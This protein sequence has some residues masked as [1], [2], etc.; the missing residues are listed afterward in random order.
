VI[1]YLQALILG[2]LQG[3]TELFPVSS[4]GHSVILPR[5]F[6][7]NI[8]Q[9]DDAFVTFL[10]ATHFATA[11]TLFLYF[12]DDWRQIISGLLRTRN[13]QIAQDDHYAKLGW[14]LVV[15]TIPAGLIGLVLEHRLRSLFASA[16][17]AAIFLFFNGVMLLGAEHLRKRAPVAEAADVD[18]DATIVRRLT[19]RSAIGIGMAQAVALIPGFSRSG[20]SMS[21]GLLAGLSNEEAARF[22][23]LL[24][25][26]IIGAAALLKLPHLA[27]PSGDG[28]R[29]PALV[30]ALGAAVAAY[31]SVRFLLRFFETNRLT[32]FGIYCMIAGGSLAVVFAVT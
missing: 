4:L 18:V 31:C 12:W 17:S 19:I 32:P 11:T 13:G 20:A 23:F 30:G 27:G 25:T 26:P 9:N 29:G 2:L 15:A 21:G 24:A 10:V 6:G 1:S 14:L 8:Q 16:E 3:A 22:S 28:I 5:L 7:W